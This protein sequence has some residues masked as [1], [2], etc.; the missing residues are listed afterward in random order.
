[1]FT[2]SCQY[3][4]HAHFLPYKVRPILRDLYQAETGNCRWLTASVCTATTPVAL[5][6][7]SQCRI[8]DMWQ[9]AKF[10]SNISIAATTGEGETWKTLTNNLHSSYSLGFLLFFL[11][12]CLISFC[13]SLFISFLSVILLLFLPLMFSLF[14][15]ANKCAYTYICVMSMC[16]CR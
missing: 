10:V 5:M 15:S 3:K 16:S 1:M 7:S 8:E 12:R 11:Q 14:H 2:F 6:T 9:F 4:W 13:M